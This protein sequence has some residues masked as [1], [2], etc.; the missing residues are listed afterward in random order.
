[1]NHVVSFPDLPWFYSYVCFYNNGRGKQTVNCI[2][3]KL[4]QVR[5]LYRVPQYY[6]AGLIS[7]ITMQHTKTTLSIEAIHSCSIET[8]SC[9]TNKPLHDVDWD[10][11]SWIIGN[12]WWKNFYLKLKKPQNHKHVPTNQENL[13]K[14]KSSC[15]SKSRSVLMHYCVNQHSCLKL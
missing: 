7:C 4:Q 2:F 5:V 15:I 11:S 14:I 9:H 10:F 3:V 13:W 6:G 1:M 8:T 12:C